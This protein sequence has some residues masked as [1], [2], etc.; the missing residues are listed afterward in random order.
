MLQGTVLVPLLLNIYVIEIAH[1]QRNS[2]LY[3][4]ADDDVISFEHN[5]YGGAVNTLQ[6]DICR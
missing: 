4:F 6:L 3:Q 1:M 5:D 2:S